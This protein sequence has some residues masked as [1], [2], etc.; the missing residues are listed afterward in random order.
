MPLFRE[1]TNRSDASTIFAYDGSNEADS[2]KDVPFWVSLTL[3]P[4]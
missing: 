2:R 3:L 4:T 1:L